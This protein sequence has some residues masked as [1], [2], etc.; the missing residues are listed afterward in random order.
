MIGKQTIDNPEKTLVYALV[1]ETPVPPCI[2]PEGISN[3][4]TPS[5]GGEDNPESDGELHFRL[6]D[7]GIRQH[8]HSAR[9]HILKYRVDGDDD[10]L[11]TAIIKAGKLGENVLTPAKEKQN[12]SR[13]TKARYST[14]MD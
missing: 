3:V 2:L 8:F 5:L 13:P 7:E 9:P 10:C 14:R 4:L 11:Y 1:T 12:G 6:C